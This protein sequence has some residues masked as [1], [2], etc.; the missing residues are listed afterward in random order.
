MSITQAGDGEYMKSQGELSNGIDAEK[1]FWFFIFAIMILSAV[2]LLV[3][4]SRMAIIVVIFLA[5]AFAL[6]KY[7]GKKKWKTN[8]TRQKR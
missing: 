5:I 2:L 3:E 7:G 1:V 6:F 8:Q 4:R